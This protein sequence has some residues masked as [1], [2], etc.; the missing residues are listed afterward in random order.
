MKHTIHD[1]GVASQI[2]KYSDAIETAPSL[3]WLHTSGA[4]GLLRDKK[5]PADVTGQ[6]D[7]AWQQIIRILN[8]AEMGVEDI[9][10]VSQYVT[11]AEDIPSYIK[12]RSQALGNTL[13]AFVLLVVPQLI[14]PE[15][16]VEVTAANTINEY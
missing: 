8:Q 6:A 5:L 3:R 15:V 9:V 4:P 2:G 7:L 12:V 16:L 14:W 11:R 13:P 10:R 1:I